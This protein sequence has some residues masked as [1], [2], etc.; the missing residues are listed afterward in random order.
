MA[1]SSPRLA[2]CAATSD[3]RSHWWQWWW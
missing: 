1:T 2:L 3:W